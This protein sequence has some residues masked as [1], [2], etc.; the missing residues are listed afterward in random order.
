MNQFKYYKDINNFS[1][2]ESSAFTVH[3]PKMIK[4][5]P[6]LLNALARVLKFPDYFGHNWDALAECLRDFQWLK[7]NKIMIVHEDLPQLDDEALA[8][9]LDVLL[10]CLKHWEENKTDYQDAFERKELQVY[11]PLKD[12]TKIEDIIKYSKVEN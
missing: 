11:F 9:Y 10:F 2:E 4:E 1:N 6:D 7:E 12:K 5:K 8:L 3:M